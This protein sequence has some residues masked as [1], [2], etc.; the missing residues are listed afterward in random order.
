[1]KRNLKLRDYKKCLKASQTENKINYLEKKI[2]V[3]CYKEDRVI[4]KTQQRF[5]SERYNAF[6]EIIKKIALSSND[7]KRVKSIVLAETYAYGTSKDLICKKE[8]IKC[9]NI[10]KQYKN[11]LR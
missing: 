2:G 8:K 6:I 5:Q 9:N 7:G 10:I 3:D 11:V 4:L 1:M